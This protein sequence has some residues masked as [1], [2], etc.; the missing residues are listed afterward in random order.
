MS[1]INYEGYGIY[2]EVI[3]EGEPLLMIHGNTASSK[4]LKEEAKYY[5]NYYKIILVDMIGHG[6][7]KRLEVFPKD[8]WIENTKVIFELCNKLKLN[9]INILGTSGGAILALNFAI[10]K[11]EIVNKVI[12]DSFIGEKLTIQEAKKIKEER[13]IAKK[14]GGDKFWYYMHGED[15]EKVV[16][17]DSE[18][19]INYAREYGNNFKNNLYKITCPVLITGSLND[20][21]V[22]NIDK[23]L[24]G[25]AKQIKSSLTIFT[26]EGEHPLML[27]KNEF[28]RNITIKFLKGD[29]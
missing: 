13:Q 9:K 3:G 1:Y 2:Y 17:A 18:M 19:L 7:S 21:L 16:D 11:S 25:V 27:S 5:S 4:M 29:L 24:T 15:W 22:K 10:N 26:S 28:Y 23:R 8:Y 14:N 6:K 20:N 12:A